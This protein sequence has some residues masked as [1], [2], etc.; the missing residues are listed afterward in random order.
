VCMCV[1]ACVRVCLGV[2]ACIALCVSAQIYVDLGAMF[3]SY[4]Y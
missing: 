1:H 4:Y 2:Y 3:I